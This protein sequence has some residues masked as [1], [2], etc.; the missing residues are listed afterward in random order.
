MRELTYGMCW[1]VKRDLSAPSL[2]EALTPFRDEVERSGIT[3][4]EL[5]ALVEQAREARFHERKN[6]SV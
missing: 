4:D 6:T 5:D 3:E 1:S 2:D